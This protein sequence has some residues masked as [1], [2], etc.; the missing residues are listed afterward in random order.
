MLKVVD[1]E[2][3]AAG[4]EEQKEVLLDMTRRGGD[5]LTKN[6]CWY[7]FTSPIVRYETYGR[8]WLEAGC[9]QWTYEDQQ[10]TEGLITE[11]RTTQ[12]VGHKADTLAGFFFTCE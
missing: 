10:G 2:D 7:L 1:D 5:S 8:E 12:L 11:T 6:C 3:G 4:D 9:V